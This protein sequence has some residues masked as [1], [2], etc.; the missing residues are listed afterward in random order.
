MF[1]TDPRST[2]TCTEARPPEGPLVPGLQ[3]PLAPVGFADG[4]QQTEPYL[5]GLAIS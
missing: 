4:A 5:T 2:Q 3:N 1:V